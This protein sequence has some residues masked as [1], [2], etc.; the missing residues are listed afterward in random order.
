MGVKKDLFG[1]I[2]KLAGTG[3]VLATNTSALDVNRI[4][5]ASGRASGCV[6]MHFFSPANIMKLVEVVRGAETAPEVLATAMAVCKRI[7]KIGVVSGVCDGFIG[8]RMLRG[9]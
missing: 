5:A 7:G 8:N 4:A 6:G 2:G 1:K 9:Y 3:A